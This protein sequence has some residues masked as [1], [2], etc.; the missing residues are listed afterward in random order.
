MGTNFKA[1][2]CQ[3]YL[4]GI[5]VKEKLGAPDYPTTPV[6]IERGEGSFFGVC[7]IGHLVHVAI[8]AAQIMVDCEKTPLCKVV[9]KA[10]RWV[11]FSCK[12]K[13]RGVSSEI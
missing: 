6:K 11:I 2:D 5:E 3:P 7:R 9:Y 8:P 10:A 4:T 1:P 13:I 12:G